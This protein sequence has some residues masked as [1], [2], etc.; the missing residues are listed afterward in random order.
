MDHSS[1]KRAE[2]E[3]ARRVGGKRVPVSGR[4]RGDAPDVQHP[5]LAIEVKHRKKLPEW[6]LDALDQ[7]EKSA[8]LD[9]IPVVVLHEARQRYDRSLVLLRLEKLME[10]LSGIGAGA[11]VWDD[12]RAD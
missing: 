11:G 12:G 10:L 4:A 3:I 2:L 7:V 5:R 6:L 1:W 8:V 9:Q